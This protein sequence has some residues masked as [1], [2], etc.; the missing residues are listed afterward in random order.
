MSSRLKCDEEEEP[1]TSAIRQ[2]VCPNNLNVARLMSTNLGGRRYPGF[3][4]LVLS[5][6]IRWVLART[7]SSE[8]FRGTH[9]V[10]LMWDS[11]LD[12]TALHRDPFCTRAA[13]GLPARLGEATNLAG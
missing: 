9:C 1:L 4:A 8:I 2:R 6:G 7:A 3:V 5:Y 12:L 11:I 10:E 13:R